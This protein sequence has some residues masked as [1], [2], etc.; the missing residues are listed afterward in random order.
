[1]LVVTVPTSGIAIGRSL[2][3][4]AIP[5][6]FANPGSATMSEAIAVPW[7]NSSRSWSVRPSWV[8]SPKSRPGSTLPASSGM[9]AFTPL[10]ISAI[11]MP[12][13]RAPPAHTAG[14][15]QSSNH[16]CGAS[17]GPGAA[18]AGVG[19]KTTAIVLATTIAAPTRR[20][21]ALMRSAR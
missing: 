12:W 4:G 3:S 5:V 6:M 20:V 21:S 19:T 10:S 17:G 14:M 9:L 18:S 8:G 11:V 13:P 2:A 15:S 7:P 1:M 16:H